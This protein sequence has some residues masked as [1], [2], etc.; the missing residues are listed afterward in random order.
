MRRR[1][2]KQTECPCW[3]QRAQ[4]AP[5]SPARA[6]HGGA[7]RDRSNRFSYL[8]HYW[9]GKP[10]FV[11]ICAALAV[12]Y[13]IANRAPARVG[14][15]ETDTSQAKDHTLATAE[16]LK[17]AVFRGPRVV[18]QGFQKGWFTVP[19]AARLTAMQQT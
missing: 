15:S 6:E 17:M 19:R 14:K 4:C 16:A 1:V 12:P 11:T 2:Q 10:M 13:H 7:A 9:Y 18:V 5:D 3:A 8:R